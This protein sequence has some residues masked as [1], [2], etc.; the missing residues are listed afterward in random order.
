MG[1]ESGPPRAQDAT[2]AEL[3]EDFPALR[4][5]LARV[6]DRVLTSLTTGDRRIDEALRH[7]AARPGRYL[8]PSLTLTSAYLV[9]GDTPT[10]ERTV[11]AATAVETLHLA[12]LHHDDLCD[13]A[14][15]RRGRATA[16]ARYG[17]DV[18]LVLGDYL[19]TTAL[20]QAASLGTEESRAAVRCAQRICVGQLMELHDIGRPERSVESYMASI[21]GK[22]AELLSLSAL[23]GGLTA[24]ASSRQ[25]KVLASYAYELGVAFQIWNDVRDLRPPAG[26]AGATPHSADLS[27]GVYTLPV[28]HGL[29]R[30]GTRLRPLI[31]PGAGPEAVAEAIR[32]LENSGSVATAVATANQHLRQ[33]LDELGSLDGAFRDA[34]QRILRTM[35]LLLPEMDALV[36]PRP[37]QSD[38]RGTD[39]SSPEDGR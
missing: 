29:R 25:T 11:T 13:Q 34:P 19:L 7:L 32:V 15:E 22:T 28:I 39:R 36:S 27:H 33:S 38:V 35:R 37:H 12:T 3:A 23:L 24:G 4:G 30:A 8:R 18:A 21:S 31:G 14:A 5:D 6:H 16:N 10:S 26:P 1:A 20:G 9:A 2:S 17:D